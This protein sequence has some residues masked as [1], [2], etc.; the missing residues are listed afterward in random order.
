MQSDLHGHSLGEIPLNIF[1]IGVFGAL[2]DPGQL[3]GP[4]VRPHL[5]LDS[6]SADGKGRT[7][8]GF[9]GFVRH[10]LAFA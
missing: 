6:M 10:F 2:G 8:K 7:K 3:E 9:P 5:V 4:K 1:Q